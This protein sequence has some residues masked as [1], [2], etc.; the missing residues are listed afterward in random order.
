MS[1]HRAFD[2]DLY[3]R[4]L[5][6]LLKEKALESRVQRDTASDEDRIFALG[7]LMAFHEIISLMQQQATAFGISLD[8]LGLDDIVPE[9]DLV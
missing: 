1:Q 2:L 9:R 5:V 8:E 7:R 3:F 4:D 6:V